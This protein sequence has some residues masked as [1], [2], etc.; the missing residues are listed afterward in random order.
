VNRSARTPAWEALTP[1]RHRAGLSMADLYFR[2]V[3][4]GGTASAALLSR[5]FASGVLAPDQHDLA[6]LALNERFLEIDDRERLPYTT[7]REPESPDGQPGA[8]RR[9]HRDP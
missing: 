3:A 4:L 7:S 6:V 1:A 9:A 2:Y 8:G 5:H